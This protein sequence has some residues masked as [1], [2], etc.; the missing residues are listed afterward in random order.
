MN[1]PGSIKK[2][3]R[4]IFKQDLYISHHLAKTAGLTFLKVL[5]CLFNDKL[6]LDY[7]GQSSKPIDARKIP[8][9][10]KC[11]HGHFNQPKYMNYLPEAKWITWLRDPIERAISNYYHMFRHPEP[12]DSFCMKVVNRNMALEDFLKLEESYR[13]YSRYNNKKSFISYDFVGITEEFEKGLKLFF[14]LFNFPEDKN[15][16]V[17]SVNTNPQKESNKYPLEESLREELV[18]LYDDELKLYNSMKEQ[19]YSQCNKYEI[20]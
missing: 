10:T 14:K 6:L 4:V 19:F 18:D 1:V 20:S 2:L 3:Y 16:Q 9:R 11:I 17:T 13:Y 7:F 12:G 8:L 5:K 15:I